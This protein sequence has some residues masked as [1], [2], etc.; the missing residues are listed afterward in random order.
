[1]RTNKEVVKQ[2]FSRSATTYDRY[3]DLHEQ[4]I[5][6]LFSNLA[7]DYK[8]ILDIGSGT[9]TLVNM[10]AKKY[11][12]AEA[13]GVDIAPGMVNFAASKVKQKNARF[14]AGDGEFLPFKNKEFDLVVSSASLQ[15]MDAQKVFAEAA[16]VLRPGGE[17]HFSTFGPRTLCELKRVGLAVNDLPSRGELERVLRKYFERVEFKREIIHKNYD[18]L[19]GLFVYLKMIGA[20]YPVKSCNKGLSTKSKIFSLFPPREGLAVTFEVYYGIAALE[21]YLV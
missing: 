21:H 2:N 3:A 18:G 14:L 15:W 10:L 16:R 11:P 1:M 8:R 20:Q 7:G 6:K 13:V 4:I 5:A 17:F 9:G 12:E 19:S